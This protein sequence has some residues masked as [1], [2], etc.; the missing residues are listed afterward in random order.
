MAE[1]PVFLRERIGLWTILKLDSA[2][3]RSEHNLFFRGLALIVAFS[4]LIQSAGM[5]WSR[6]DVGFDRVHLGEGRGTACPS[7]QGVPSPHSVGDCDAVRV[8][9]R[10]SNTTDWP[11]PGYPAKLCLAA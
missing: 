1:Y 7:V 6:R 4:I 3:T 2:Q 11:L 5:L 9:A 10:G 8:D